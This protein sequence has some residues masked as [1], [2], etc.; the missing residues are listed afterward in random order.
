VSWLGVPRK[1]DFMPLFARDWNLVV[2]ALDELYFYGAPYM[3]R[4]IV[5]T[6]NKRY[7]IGTPE[8]RIYALYTAY[9]DAQDNMFVQGR[10]VLRDWD[11]IYL[12]GFLAY[13]KE[14]V[15]AIKLYLIDIYQTSKSIETKVTDIYQELVSIDTSVKSVD[16]TAKDIYQVT[17]DIYQVTR[18]IETKVEEIRLYATPRAVKTL[19]LTVTTSPVPLTTEP[20]KT[21][22][23]KLRVPSTETYSI[24]LGDATSQYWF[25]APGEKEEIE[26]DSP[27]KIYL[28][29]EGTTKVYALFEVV[30]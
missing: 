29:S 23:V 8:K 6:Q 7:S 12:Y 9:V 11:P 20:L 17:S 19:E 24:W 3:G 16:A 30:E 28:R 5:P 22:R 25:I 18:S 2:D 13:A 1:R 21:K 4:D 26:I 14:D 10:R 27:T 15:D